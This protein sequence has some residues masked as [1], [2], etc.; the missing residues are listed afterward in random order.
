MFAHGSRLQEQEELLKAAQEKFKKEQEEM[1]RKQAELEAKLKKQMEE[2]KALAANKERE[3]RQRSL[4]DE[5]LLKTIPLVNEANAISE[6]LGKGMSFTVKLMANHLASSP[7]LKRA[8]GSQD[9]DDDD[10][11]DDEIVS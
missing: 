2:T 6:E 11:E 7:P 10:Y 8:K 4:L 9:E 1:L 3:M 5:K